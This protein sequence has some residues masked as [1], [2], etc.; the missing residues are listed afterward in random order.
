MQRTDHNVMH[1]RLEPDIRKGVDGVFDDINNIDRDNVRAIVV[2]I[3]YK[4]DP[5]GGPDLSNEHQ[6]H[7]TIETFSLSSKNE[8]CQV[9]VA[10]L[11]DV[12]TSDKRIVAFYIQQLLKAMTKIPE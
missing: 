4:Q 9:S 10:H 3:V 8:A 2:H 11:L 7:L 12:A 5:N 1:D 6:E